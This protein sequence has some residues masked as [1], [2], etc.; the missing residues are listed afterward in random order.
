MLEGK[1][2]LIVGLASNRSIAYGGAIHGQTRGK[3]GIAYQGESLKTALQKW[4][5]LWQRSR[6][7]AMLRAMHKLSKS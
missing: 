4:Q 6:C 3:L 7:L 2:V 1:K 5:Q